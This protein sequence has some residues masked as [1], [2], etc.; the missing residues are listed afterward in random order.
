MSLD[1]KGPE[2]FLGGVDTSR[3]Y[4]TLT[5][6]TLTYQAYWTIPFDGIKVGS[7]TLAGGDAIIDT[8][9]YFESAVLP[10]GD[11]PCHC[12]AGANV[13]GSVFISGPT[14]LVQKIYDNI[15]GAMLESKYLQAQGMSLTQDQIS[16]YRSHLRPH[17]T[18]SCF[19]GVYT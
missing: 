10:I 5:A 19:D 4:S 18:P 13:S 11:Y 17:P 14:N 8:G 7:T 12:V 9:E 16:T 3:L 1:G 2:L 6:A 15:P